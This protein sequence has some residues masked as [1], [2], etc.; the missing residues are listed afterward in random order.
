MLNAVFLIVYMSFKFV[1]YV[2]CEQ[3]KFWEYHKKKLYIQKLMNSIFIINLQS[4]NYHTK[5]SKFMKN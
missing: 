1:Y 5:T 3:I 4:I 2:I